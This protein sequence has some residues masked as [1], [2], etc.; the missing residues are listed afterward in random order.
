MGYRGRARVSPRPLTLVDGVS[1]I[2][3]VNELETRE[4]AHYAEVNRLWR[5]VKRDF[6]VAVERVGGL[7]T[8]D[9]R[10]T[11]LKRLQRNWEALCEL[12]VD[13]AAS[14]Y[15]GLNELAMSFARHGQV[16]S[17]MDRHSQ[18]LD[19]LVGII[20]IGREAN[21]D[22]VVTTAGELYKLGE[23]AIRREIEDGLS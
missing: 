10:H 16:N 9:P 19:E 2:R 6:F 22:A 7:N 15:H 18:Q 21:P 14:L 4:A 11:R 3:V 1:S 17:P 20:K 23:E 12:D 8:T 13:I 5:A